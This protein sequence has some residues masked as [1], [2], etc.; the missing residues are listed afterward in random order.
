M[1]LREA[2]NRDVGTT[3]LYESR[4]KHITPYV[5]V[6]VEFALFR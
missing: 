4:N 2:K 5:L 6:E 1:A 3:A